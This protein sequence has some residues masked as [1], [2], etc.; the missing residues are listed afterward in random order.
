MIHVLYLVALTDYAEDRRAIFYSVSSAIIDYRLYFVVIIS[1]ARCLTSSQ[2]TR[3]PFFITLLAFVWKLIDTSPGS[4]EFC[5][6]LLFFAYFQLFLHLLLPVSPCLVLLLPESLFFPLS[7]MLFNLLIEVIVPVFL[8]FF[9]IF[10]VL[11]IVI[12]AYF[13]IPFL[14]IFLTFDIPHEAAWV[15]VFYILCL[16]SLIILV[17]MFYVSVISATR[18]SS[19]PVQTGVPLPWNLYGPRV[20]SSVRLYFF[21]SVRH[22]STPFFFPAPFNLIPFVLVTV[23]SLVLR[24]C[25][26]TKAATWLHV[27]VKPV[28]W[29]FI[30][31]HLGLLFGVVWGWRRS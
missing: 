29:R 4:Q 7:S 10:V 23:P 17:L 11:L 18:S 2:V 20:A 26:Q 8:F 27:Q 19:T 28:L 30:A 14:P 3:S 25:H 9:P 6:Y 21:A 12:I 15:I 24:I 1:L 16:L 31:L 13:E 22:Y 5:F